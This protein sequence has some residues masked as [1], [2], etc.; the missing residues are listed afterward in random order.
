MWIAVTLLLTS[1]VIAQEATPTSYD[2]A[3]QRIQEAAA[4]GSTELDLSSLGLADLPPELWQLQNLAELDL[5]GNQLT[6][7]PDTLHRGPVDPN[8]NISGP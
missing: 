2:V 1:P 5:G 8:N 6:E 3:L 4:N 7:M